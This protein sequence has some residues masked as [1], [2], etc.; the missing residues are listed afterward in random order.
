MD[1]ADGL[2]ADR[3]EKLSIKRGY[4][5]RWKEAKDG[6]TILKGR[7]VRTPLTGGEWLFVPR[8]VYM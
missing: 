2:D 3:P 8:G 1:F 6:I 4:S 7:S 5:K